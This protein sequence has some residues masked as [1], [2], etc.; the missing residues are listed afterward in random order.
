MSRYLR[1]TVLGGVVKSFSEEFLALRY[2]GINFVGCRLQSPVIVLHYDRDEFDY[3][4]Y[5]D[6]SVIRSDIAVPLSYFYESCGKDS[7][8][9]CERELDEVKYGFFPFSRLSHIISFSYR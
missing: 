2:L 6:S 1:G 8:I 5:V 4:F 9:W 3:M 7:I